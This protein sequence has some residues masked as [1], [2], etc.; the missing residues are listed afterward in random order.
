LI[1]IN[2]LNDKKKFYGISENLMFGQLCP[3]GTGSFDLILNKKV[4]SDAKYIPD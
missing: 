3:I 1:L 2:I 4:L